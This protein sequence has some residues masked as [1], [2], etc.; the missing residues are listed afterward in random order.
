MEHP[1]KVHGSAILPVPMQTYTVVD[2]SSHETGNAGEMAA[3][4]LSREPSLLDTGAV[5]DESSDE[6]D[7]GVERW[8]LNMPPKP[9]KT[10]E[11]KRSDIAVFDLW[12]EENREQISRGPNR[13]IS[14]PDEMPVAGLVG[15]FE[16]GKIIASPRDYQ[17][18]LFER[19]KEKNIIAVLDTGESL[20]F[21]SFGDC[22][23][24][25]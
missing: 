22:R 10:S 12:I 23:N 1:K 18:E 19:A 7:E 9:R 16:G 25:N 3:G 13:S 21:F 5:R 6:A 2:G 24:T 8:I 4:G 14:V 15:D 20:F 11:K 17:V